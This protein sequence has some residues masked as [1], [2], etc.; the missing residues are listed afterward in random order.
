M[1]ELSGHYVGVVPD[2]SLG[3]RVRPMVD[4]DANTVLTIYQI[5]LDSGD[6][7]FAGMAPNWAEFTSSRLPLHRFV[8]IGATGAVVGWVAGSGV[9]DRCVYS[10]VVEH[11]VYVHPDARGRGVGRALLAAFLA[12]TESAGIWTVQAGIF[13]DNEASLALHAALGF[14]VVGR[15]E[16]LGRDPRTGRWRDVI[17]LERRSVVAGQSEA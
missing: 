15:R 12:S 8:A 17:L 6:A 14:R 13:P 11:S 10:G 5:G 9:S 16:R 4:A 7:S 3:V 1:Q 2:A